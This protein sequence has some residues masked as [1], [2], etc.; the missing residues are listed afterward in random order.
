[1]HSP[2]YFDLRYSDGAD[3]DTPRAL[4]CIIFFIFSS[5]EAS[6]KFFNSFTWA[7]SN[8]FPHGFPGLECNIPTKLITNSVFSIAFFMLQHYFGIEKFLHSE[9]SIMYEYLFYSLLKH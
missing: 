5:L 2:A 7:S 9:S 4:I 8:S 1:M 3:F 6:T